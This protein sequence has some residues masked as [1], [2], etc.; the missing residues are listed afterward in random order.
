ML[1]PTDGT[2]LHFGNKIAI[3]HYIYIICCLS[4]VV[5]QIWRPLKLQTNNTNVNISVLW[6]NWYYNYFVFPLTAQVQAGQAEKQIKT[7]FERLH[8]VLV[9]EENRRLHLLA[10]EEGQKVAKIETLISRTKEDILSLDKVIQ[11][12]KK[13]MGDEDLTLLLVKLLDYIAAVRFLFLCPSCIKNKISFS[14]DE[15][16]L[17]FYV[18]EFQGA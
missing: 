4:Y 3:I 8:Q 15:L 16:S 17:F 2:S 18:T 12:V 1:R 11:S 14:N 6:P 5:F 7:E 10:T 9:A 13:E